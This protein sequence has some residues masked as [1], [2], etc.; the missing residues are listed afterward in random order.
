MA[1]HS[2]PR[3][4]SAEKAR[5]SGSSRL[6]RPSSVAKAMA[7]KTARQAHPYRESAREIIHLLEIGNQSRPG[8]LPAESFLGLSA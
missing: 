1:G 6:A 2:T 5:M 3:I 7:D 4:E 8:R